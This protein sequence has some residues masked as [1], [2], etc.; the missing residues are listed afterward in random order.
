[1]PLLEI[2]LSRRGKL[3]NSLKIINHFMAQKIKDE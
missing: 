1:M 2:N 3:K